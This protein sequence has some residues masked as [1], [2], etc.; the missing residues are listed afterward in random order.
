[1]SFNDQG[2]LVPYE[3]PNPAILS[4]LTYFQCYICGQETNSSSLMQY[5]IKSS[6][7]EF[8]IAH[9]TKMSGAP[10]H[11]YWQCSTC[12][13]VF[14]SEVEQRMHQCGTPHPNW[15]GI[16]SDSTFTCEQCGDH[17]KGYEH[18]LFHMILFHFPENMEKINKMD[19]LGDS[20]KECKKCEYRTLDTKKFKCHMI[21][22][23]VGKSKCDQCDKSFA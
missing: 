18:Y 10:R 9:V 2:Q 14:A 22:Y 12:K 16:S 1:M 5:H 3:K 8:D 17:I 4:A 15:L 7:P 23:H 21:N 19:L 13:Q 11:L 6:H 20:E